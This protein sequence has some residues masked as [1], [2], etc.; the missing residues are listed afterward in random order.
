[1]VTQDVGFD[2]ALSDL[3]ALGVVIL[4]WFNN[5]DIPFFADAK[6]KI[7]KSIRDEE[8]EL[9]ADATES[10]RELLQGMLCKDPA[11]RWSVAE[12]LQCSWF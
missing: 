3:W 4:T 1:M 8:P 9:P 6:H 11:K 5:G 7:E 2:P 12:V 10:F